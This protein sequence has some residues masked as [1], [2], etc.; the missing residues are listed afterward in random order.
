MKENKTKPFDEKTVFQFNY[1]SVSKETLNRIKMNL[2]AEDLL[3]FDKVSLY[4]V[5]DVYKKKN[6]EYVKLIDS[7][8]QKINKK[9]VSNFKG[10]ELLDISSFSDFSIDVCLKDENCKS[11]KVYFFQKN[12]DIYIGKIVN[13]GYHLFDEQK[14][15][16][17]I[18]KEIQ[19]LFSLESDI[20]KLNSD[21]KFNIKNDFSFKVHVYFRNVVINIPSVLE[22]KLS[23]L[24]DDVSV[25]C[26]S[27][28]VLSCISGNEVELFKRIFVKIDDLPNVIREDLYIKRREYLKDIS[29][30]D[31]GHRS[32]KQFSLKH[33]F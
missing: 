22:L 21:F 10:Y 14:L 28:N 27:Y 5:H 2:L 9:I 1:Y 15:L 25:E 24:N 6:D 17:N 13:E 19:E 11:I 4:D 3:E 20:N 29:D 18:G 16:L 32:N 26:N 31:K 7:L 33:L 12:D 23:P 30:K 8:K